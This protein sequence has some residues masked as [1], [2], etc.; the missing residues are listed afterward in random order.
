MREIK[1]KGK[2]ADNGEWVY[3]GYFR[4]INRQLCPIGD[5]LKDD[6]VSHL[7]LESGFADWNMSK[8][9]ITHEVIP[10][11]LGQFIGLTDKNKKEIFSGDVLKTKDGDIVDVR[12]EAIYASFGIWKE[13]WA[14]LHYFHEA[15]EPEDCEIIGNVYDNTEPILDS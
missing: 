5:K 12:Y 2:R 15:V 11:T 4:H 13:G 7:I 14:F 10:E 6:D 9:I 8:P 1:F 3:G